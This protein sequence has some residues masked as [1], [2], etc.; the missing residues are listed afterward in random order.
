MA[1]IRLSKLTKQF[2]IGLST[3]VEFLQGKGIDV[4][5]N[6]NAKISDE[7]LPALEAKFGEEQK[8]KQD[9]EKV[10]IKLKEIIE[11]GNKKKG[12]NADEEDE[13]V[14]EIIIKS[15]I[16]A[17]EGPSI[18]EAPAKQEVQEEVL[19]LETKPKATE[20]DVKPAV[21]QEKQ[22]TTQEK[23]VAPAIGIKVVDKIDLSKLEGKPEKK[24]KDT[25]SPA[26]AETV[27]EV[28]EKPVVATKKE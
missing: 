27:S 13:P 19:E 7:H 21:Q 9:S 15:N 23:P 3:L 26:P 6:P 22:E 2:N 5:M 14:K 10:A 4:D 20:D 1:D 18:Q 24:D 16:I 28:K 25:G 12:G 11:M 8:L 17:P